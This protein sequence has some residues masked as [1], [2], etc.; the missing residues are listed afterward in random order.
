MPRRG[1]GGVEGARHRIQG[2]VEREDGADHLDHVEE[3]GAHGARL[4]QRD[5]GDRKRDH[6][7][8]QR[9]GADVARRPPPIAAPNAAKA[10]AARHDRHYDGREAAPVDVHEQRQAGEHQQGHATRERATPSPIFSPSRAR[11]PHQSPDQSRVGVLLPLQRQRTGD[12]EHGH[13]HQRHGRGDG[14][15]ERVEAR[16]RARDD[17][18]LDLDRV[19]DRGEQRLG[20]VEVLARP[21]ARSGSPVQRVGRRG[22]SPAAR[23]APTRGSAGVVQ[24]RGC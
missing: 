8:Q 11:S 4:D 22:C 21:G 20:Q 10:G 6:E 1:A 16:R 18:L 13:E 2:G 3:A 5:E 24:A 19:R 17:L 7:G 12:Q 23:S 15:R 14:D 9:A